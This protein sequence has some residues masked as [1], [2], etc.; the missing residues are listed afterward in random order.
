MIQYTPKKAHDKQNKDAVD[1]WRNIT[2][3]E[4]AHQI[5]KPIGALRLV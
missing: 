1:I 5:G 4:L 3:E 2:V